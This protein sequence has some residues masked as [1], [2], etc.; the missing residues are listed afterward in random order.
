[1]R[2]GESVLTSL[3]GPDH[4]DLSPLSPSLLH[5]KPFVEIDGRFYTFYHSGF[6]DSI[7]EIIEADIFAK[8]PD[9]V[10]D[11]TARRGDRLESDARQLLSG[12]IQPDF[13]FENVYYPNPDD[14]GI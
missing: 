14:Q 13:V 11:M 5:H 3:T 4:D 2:P 10:T 6:E 1:M 8:R 9:D 12:L 7:A